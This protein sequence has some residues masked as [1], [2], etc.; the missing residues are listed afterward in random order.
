MMVKGSY[1]GVLE[2][3]DYMKKLRMVGPITNFNRFWVDLLDADLM[4]YYKERL[5]KDLE[6]DNTQKWIE[7]EELDNKLKSVKELILLGN[8]FFADKKLS[9]LYKKCRILGIEVKVIKSNV[10]EIYRDIS[11]FRYEVPILSISSVSADEMLPLLEV[12]INRKLRDCGYNV[13]QYVSFEGGELLGLHNTMEL[14]DK[15]EGLN[16]KQVISINKKLQESI[17]A[18]DPD[19][20]VI[21]IP[22]G[23]C[24]KGIYDYNNLGIEAYILTQGISFDCNIQLIG[25]GNYTSSDLNKLSRF[26]KERFEIEPDLYVVSQNYTMQINDDIVPS[27]EIGS[28][29]LK[30]VKELVHVLNKNI[31]IYDV[32]NIRMIVKKIC[33]CLQQ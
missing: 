10:K 20:I 14:F 30:S 17:K 1:T 28:V 4:F 29:D 32:M 21:G 26:L 6:L 11:L 5:Q 16:G 13:L 18:V 33:D 3:G 27:Y 12:N 9:D 2:V 24:G 19:V 7:F 8:D 15:V 25:Y 31:R 22:F 23:L